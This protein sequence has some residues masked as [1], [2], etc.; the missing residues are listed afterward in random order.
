MRLCLEA[1]GPFFAAASVLSSYSLILQ[2][3]PKVLRTIRLSHEL[4]FAKE[5]VEGP[6]VAEVPNSRVERASNAQRGKNTSRLNIY[7]HPVKPVSLEW[8]TEFR[9][10]IYSLQW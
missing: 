2:L 6:R 5:R 3:Y 10:D 8:H 9:E 4:F 1:E 7:F